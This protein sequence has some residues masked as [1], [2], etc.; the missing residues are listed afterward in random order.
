MNKKISDIISLVILII[1]SIISIFPFYMM[2]VM[3]TR[4]SQDV[5][6]RLNLFPGRYMLTNA[7]MVFE[8]GFIRFYWNSFY[9]AFLAAAFGVLMSAMAGYALAKFEFRL[10][11]PI[12]NI[13]LGV[14]MIPFGVSI[15]GFLIEMNNFGWSNSHLPLI[16]SAMVSP[17]GV[18]LMSQFM[19]DGVPKEI[20]ESARIDGSSEAGIFFRHALPLTKAASVTLFLLIFIYSWNN[21]LIPL[22][23]VNKQTMYTIPLGLFALGNQYRQEYGARMFAL[24]L[25]TIPMLV[26]FAVN[27]KSLIRGLT[28]GAIKG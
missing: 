9:I 21:F 3:A 24:M 25:A 23:F 1:I 10:Q 7:K 8:S 13:V 27:S 14:M 6:T 16:V 19:K 18:F 11:K 4:E 26:I 15:I 17:Y 12:F 20:I 2:I 22:V 5:I 28:A